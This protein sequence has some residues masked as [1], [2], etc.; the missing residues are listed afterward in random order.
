MTL[1]EIYK[2]ACCGNEEAYKFICLWNKHCHRVDDFVDNSETRRAINDILW[3]QF[4][5]CHNLFW[6]QNEVAL[7][8]TTAIV[9]N[10]YADSIIMTDNEDCKWQKDWGNYLRFSGNQMIL[11]VALICGGYIKMRSVS[12]KLREWAYNAHHDNEGNP[13]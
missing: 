13:I 3:Q 8:V 10:D 5:L 7:I 2:D 9:I 1:D 12:M 6:K 4:E 11:A